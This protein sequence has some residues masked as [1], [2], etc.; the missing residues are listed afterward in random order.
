MIPAAGISMRVHK[1][2]MRASKELARE[3][4]VRG[5]MNIQFAVKD[6][7]LYVIEVNPRASRTVPFASKTIG[8]P[9]AKLAAKVMAGKTLT[10]LGFTEEILPDYYSFKEAVFPWNRFPG[11]DVVL[12]PEMRSTGEVMGI[13]ADPDIA[14]A[15]AQISAFNALPKSGL[16]FISVN[17]RDKD[18]IIP[19]AKSLIRLGF[20][21]CATRGTMVHLLQ[22]DIECER[23][24]KVHE[25]KRPNIVDRIKNGEIAFIINTP[26][27]H[28]AR[29]DDVLIRSSAVATKTS[30]CTNLASARAC[31]GAMEGT[32]N[33]SAEVKTLQEFHGLA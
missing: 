12:G 18:A 33:K 24:Y 29:K 26:G 15:K 10:E 14:F 17:D 22:H 11:I 23:A 16:V 21:L 19:L 13:D 25:G 32:F 6:E 20:D 2:I 8:K 28:D 9:L 1:E 4:E 31:V 5:L 30:Y 3:L 7:Q 27:S